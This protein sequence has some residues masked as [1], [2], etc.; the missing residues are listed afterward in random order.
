MNLAT[1]RT[2]IEIK[3]VNQKAKNDILGFISECESFYY[4]QIKEIANQVNKLD[5][6]KIILLAGPS[7]AG[8]TTS[9]N[10]I[11]KELIALG[12]P[13]EVIS[14]DNF[15]I[16]RDV[17]PIL[18]DGSFDFE[19]VTTVDIP[20]FKNFID[21]IFLNNTAK[22]PLFNFISGMREEKYVDLTIEK[23]G[24][25]I[26]EGIHAL[27][28]IILNDHE[29]EVYK[30]FI[31][32]NLEYYDNDTKIVHVRELRRIRR[33]IRD[34]YTRGIKPHETLKN[35]KNV[36]NGEKKFIFPFKEYADYLVNSSHDYEILVYKKY[37]PAL[38]DGS[39]E[40][41]EIA[42]DLAYF[43]ELDIS[44]VPES[45]LIFQE[46]LSGISH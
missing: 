19:N 37:I 25:L 33:M 29:N 31:N 46:F 24:I 22:M 23:N 43:D 36:I 10:L 39:D 21:E 12:K 40:A 41:N 20:Y 7:S 16:N 1:E 35:W 15:F 42:E 26:I 27:N 44:F 34:F 38:L 30:V 3:E 17:T 8:K 14:M 9:A 4:N 6:V 5:K 45:S 32:P 2:K 18:E 11:K 28:P 13:A